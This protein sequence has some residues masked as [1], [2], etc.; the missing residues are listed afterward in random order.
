MTGVE[1][2]GE[3]DDHGEEQGVRNSEAGSEQGINSPEQGDGF[4]ET[5]DSRRA[6][7]GRYRGLPNP[8]ARGGGHSRW[9]QAVPRA[10]GFRARSVCIA[11][12]G[13]ATS[14]SCG[15]ATPSA[16]GFPSARALT[17][18]CGTP[19]AAIFRIRRNA[20]GEIGDRYGPNSATIEARLERLD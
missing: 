9:R 19:T 6:S 16:L 7:A 5:G 10:I 12:R 1:S 18:I 20:S 2:D 8:R 11:V 3:S 13:A 15:A 17:R 4:A 14:R